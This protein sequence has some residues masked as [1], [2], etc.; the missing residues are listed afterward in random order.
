MVH[1]FSSVLVV[2]QLF[3][4]LSGCGRVSTRLISTASGRIDSLSTMYRCD[5]NNWCCSATGN[6]TTCCPDQ[7]YFK[8][9]RNSL[10]Q[11]QNGSA[12]VPGYTISPISATSTWLPTGAISV[13]QAQVQ[14][15][16]SKDTVAAGVGTGVG[17]GVPLLA[18]IGSLV[19]L[20]RRQKQRYEQEHNDVIQRLSQEIKKSECTSHESQYSGHAETS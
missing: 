17:I 16:G 14:C 7:H 9:P 6:A 11:V 8:L 2:S 12:F 18:V 13:G 5:D 4:M 15:N 19:F 3:S 10:A 1:A 20:L